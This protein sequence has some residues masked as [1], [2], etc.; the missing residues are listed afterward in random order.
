MNALD[1]GRWRALVY[2]PIFVVLIGLAAGLW[3]RP[4]ALTLCYLVMSLLMLAVWHRRSDVAFFVL[5]AL[6]GPAGE[7]VA[8]EFGAWSYGEPWS[9]VPVWL[10]LGWGIAGLYL[11]RTVEVLTPDG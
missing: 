8:V 10:P 2:L 7:W 11:K 6:L 3:R 1:R 4:L 5:A 9:N